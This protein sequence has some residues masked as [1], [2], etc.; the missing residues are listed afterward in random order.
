MPC[1][2]SEHCC[3]TCCRNA[4]ASLRVRSFIKSQVFFGLNTFSAVSGKT[5]YA[6]VLQDI[7]A[8]KAEICH[9]YFE[10]EIS[11]MVRNPDL[12]V[13][14]RTERTRDLFEDGY[15]KACPPWLLKVSQ[16]T[17]AYLL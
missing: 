5:W 17:A 15:V 6:G 4:E 3:L 10:K 1:C 14:E 11:K 8:N 12:S 16:S 2:L 13:A 7:R 9:I